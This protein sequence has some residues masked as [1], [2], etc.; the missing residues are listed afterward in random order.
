RPALARPRPFT[1]AD[2]AAIA[3]CPW[4]SAGFLTSEAGWEYG[5]LRIGAA[6]YHIGRQGRR[7]GIVCMEPAA[8]IAESPSVADAL[9]LFASRFPRG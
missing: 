2:R 5:A 8:V 1:P 6:D 3:L 4:A 9:P 7:V